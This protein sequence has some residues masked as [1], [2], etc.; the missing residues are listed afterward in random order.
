MS[1]AGWTT[2]GVTKPKAPRPQ[3]AMVDVP[4]A[5]WCDEWSDDERALFVMLRN[6]T[7][8]PKTHRGDHGGMSAKQLALE[9]SASSG[10]EHTKESV[11]KLLY[12]DNMAP[13]LVRRDGSYDRLWHVAV[14]NKK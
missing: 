10:E 6:A 14:T 3:R 5:D 2:V 12:G 7:K 8:V 13:Y 4:R 9:L 11:G 1:G